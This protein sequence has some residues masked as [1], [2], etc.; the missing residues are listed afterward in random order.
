MTDRG[1]TTRPRRARRHRPAG[2]LAFW[3]L[4]VGGCA[5][6]PGAAPDDGGVAGD[7]RVADAAR[8]PDAASGDARPADAGHD[9]SPVDAGGSDS[10]AAL[11]A[12]PNPLGIH[13][14]DVTAQVGTYLGGRRDTEPLGV[15][16]GAA[17]G[18][19]DGDGDLD[20]FLARCDAGGYPGG[21]PVLLRQIGGGGFS[22][23][24]PSGGLDAELA[25]RCA[26]AAAFADHDGDGDLDL[27]VALHGADRLYANDGT[28]AFTDV[29]ATAGVAGPADQKSTGALWADVNADGLLDLFV[30]AQ[31][32][33]IDPSDSPRNR[34]RLHLN[35]GGGLFEDVS[36][37]AGI[38]GDGVSHAAAIADLD[39]DGAL[40]IYVANDR[41]AID[42]GDAK[43]GLDPDAF[44]DR[45]ALDDQGRPSYVDRSAAYQLDGPRSS[46]GVAL[47]DLE[48]D[49]RDEIYV[50]DFGANHL[51][52][53]N[54]SLQRYDE[55]A[56]DWN[57]AFS[58]GLVTYYVSWAARF[59]D[60]DRDGA[61]EL[62]VINGSTGPAVSC[63][64]YRQVDLLLRRGLGAASFVDVTALVGWPYAFSCPPPPSGVQFTGRGLVVADL[65]GD[66][67]DDLV[68]TPYI[69]HYAFFRNDTP[70]AHAALRVRP[71]GT[72]S[73]SIPV[74][75]VLDVV[76][77]DGIRL[78]RS[79]HA[80]GATLSQSDHVLEVGLGG[81]QVDEAWLRWPSGHAQRLDTRPD[82]V[83]GETWT[84]TEPDWL[85]LSARVIA[86]DDP[87]PVLTF[88]PVDASGAPTGPGAQVSV[89]RSDGVAAVVVDEGDGRYTATL[90][91]P[92]VA[93][94]T[95]L[96]IAVDGA[97]LA[98]R[99]S[100]RYR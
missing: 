90:P 9:A 56:D 74:G 67:D 98:P 51:S 59:V 60:L 68:V 40:E 37:S 73:A 46:M 54:P 92:G 3:A 31:A 97:P 14:V 27:F 75:A 65:D 63:S 6:P 84:V 91:H 19:V 11:P 77:T 1:S 72:A 53:W 23:F 29:T 33:Q 35:R 43:P 17:V 32:Y 15:G 93:R 48:G 24:V 36:A 87:T 76:R 100:L 62:A 49:G 21:P 66:H 4:V 99:P 2:S 34:N 58:G 61:E 78:R 16:S 71:V 86:A 83:L 85:R 52:R 88:E 45:V 57:A 22:A 12:D 79:L 64:Q 70:A 38:Q 89:T 39:G 7:A 10:D 82:F 30:P 13:L 28:G 20:L 25:T 95:V 8:A 47:G 81:A 50:T 80:G 18:D 69:E 44:H 55:V 41:F 5:G 26:H 42:G 96:A 94:I